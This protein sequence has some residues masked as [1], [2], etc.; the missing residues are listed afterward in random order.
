M[1]RA[2]QGGQSASAADD[3]PRQRPA[4]PE[5]T[6]K[7]SDLVI[8]APPSRQNTGVVVTLPLKTTS[9]TERVG[10]SRS[11]PVGRSENAVAG[12]AMRRLDLM[13]QSKE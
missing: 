13:G 9:A 3:F 12:E 6:S 8:D 7:P 1:R 5:G 10:V 4:F 2:L 11:M